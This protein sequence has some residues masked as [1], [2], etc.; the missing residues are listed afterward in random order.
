MFH[1]VL[2]EPTVYLLVQVLLLAAT[3]TVWWFLVAHRDRGHQPGH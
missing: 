1:S 3:F 2:S